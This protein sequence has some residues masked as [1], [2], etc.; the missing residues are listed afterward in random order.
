IRQ[1]DELAGQ[2]LLEDGAGKTFYN[3]LRDILRVYLYRRAGIASFSETSEELI[4]QIRRQDLL[5]ERFA[6]LA[7]ALRMG[8]F[9][10]FAK[11]QPGA[12]E[13]E[14]HYRIIRE[15]I[16]EVNRKLDEKDQAEA[17]MA[18]QG[19]DADKRETA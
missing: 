3:R 12:E 19:V 10:K 16:G 15:A 2:H 17:E 6:D 18:G 9:V 13:S 11:Y 8:D 1:L 5:R 4:G 14:A 7:E